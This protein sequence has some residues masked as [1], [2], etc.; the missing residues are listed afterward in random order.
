M[1][2]HTMSPAQNVVKNVDYLITETTYGNREHPLRKNVENDFVNK[3]KEIINNGGRVVV[4]AFA[5]GRVQEL[6]MILANAKIKKPIFIDGMG[7]KINKIILESAKNFND[8]KDYKAFKKA[9]NKVKIIKNKFDRQYAAK[10]KGIIL[11]TSGMLTGGPIIGYIKEIQNNPKNAILMTGYQ[12]EGTNGRTLMET[13]KLE[14][15]GIEVEPKAQHYMFD[16]S[17]HA[18]LVELKEFVKKVNPKHVIL[19][20]GDDDA[21]LFFKNWLVENNYNVIVPDLNEKI[22]LN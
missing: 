2:I 11:T 3:I 10:Q 17:A 15:D 16:F 13:N 6:L 4:A 12:V 1:D 20:H 18:G 7:K 22:D 19:Q 14:L 9:V 21:I 5:V 8:I